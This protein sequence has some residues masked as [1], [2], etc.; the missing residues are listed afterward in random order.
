MK[1]KDFALIG[2]AV[3]LGIII[4]I[5]VSKAVFTTSSTGQQVDVVPTI[6]AFFPKPDPRYFNS[7]SI[8]FTQFIR[9][10]NN[11][12]SNPFSATAN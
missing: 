5:F 11:S 3:V 6:S 7:Q 12:N 9:I 8:D 2:G 10:G 4:S 1:P